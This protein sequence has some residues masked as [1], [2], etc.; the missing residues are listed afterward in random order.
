[1]YNNLFMIKFNLFDKL[2]YLFDLFDKKLDFDRKFLFDDSFFNYVLSVTNKPNNKIQ[3]KKEKQKSINNLLNFNNNKESKININI[4]KITEKKS[5]VK[6]ES[7]KKLYKKLALKFHPDKKNGDNDTFLK[8]N[9]FYEKN[10]LIGLLLIASEKNIYI[11]E[12]TKD[13]WNKIFEEVNNLCEFMLNN[14]NS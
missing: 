14:Y 7:V 6:H 3:K 13:E 4:N 5:I 2:N 1:M 9:D 12:I 8:I 11:D 10:L